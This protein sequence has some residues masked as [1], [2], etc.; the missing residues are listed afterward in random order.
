MVGVFANSGL[1]LFFFEGGG[2][3]WYVP[4]LGVSIKL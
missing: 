2:G 3:G 4:G 1:A